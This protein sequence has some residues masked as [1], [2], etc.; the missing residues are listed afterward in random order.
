L[1]AGI[2]R[3]DHGSI[4]VHGKVGGLLELGA[5]FHPEFSGRENVLINGVILGLSKREVR[6]RFDAI[7][8]FAE[9]EDFI[10]EPVKTYSS[11]MYMRLGF[12][13]IVHADQD[14][15][16]IDELLAV[17]DELF[18]QKC[19]DKIRELQ[20]QGKTIILVSHTLSAVE[21]WCDEVL[22][23]Q[24]GTVHDRGTPRSVIQRYRDLMTPQDGP[25]ATATSPQEEK[26]IPSEGL[27][28]K[29]DR[30]G[31]QE[32]ELVSIG[33][34][35]GTEAERYTY[36]CGD[37]ARVSIHYKV[38]RHVDALV[39]KTAILRQDGLWCSGTGTCVDGISLPFPGQEGRAEVLLER[40]DLSTGTYFLDVAV[41]ARDGR[42]YDYHHR[43]YSLALNAEDREVGII[44][45]SDRWGIRPSLSDTQY[46][47]VSQ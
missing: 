29:P 47:V 45:M 13:V 17:G 9:L 25:W 38:H 42:V 32:V 41:E 39:F 43:Q 15:L 21:S 40:L 30:W 31:T 33:L 2:Y 26:P 36:R 1:V 44:R 8:R 5:G 22:W 35:D 6:R 10:D 23:L 12:A 16:L 3:P 34:G 4:A 24:D 11:G 20:Q 28:V 46:P 37:P 27:D 14:I 19:F 18:Q 7:V